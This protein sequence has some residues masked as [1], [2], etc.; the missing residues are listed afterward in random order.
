MLAYH[1]L[2]LSLKLFTRNFVLLKSAFFLVS[3]VFETIR[4]VSED[5]IATITSSYPSKNLQE[6]FVFTKSPVLGQNLFS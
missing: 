6:F 2:L 1:R 4:Q 5:I 3:V